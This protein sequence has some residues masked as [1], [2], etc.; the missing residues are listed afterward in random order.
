MQQ[1]HIYENILDNYCCLKYFYINLAKTWV[2]FTMIMVLFVD[3]IQVVL[4]FMKVF[5]Q[6]S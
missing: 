5:K 4:L 3:F 6:E 2:F 1:F